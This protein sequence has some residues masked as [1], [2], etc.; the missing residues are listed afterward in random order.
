MPPQRR[1]AA[2]HQAHAQHNEALLDFLIADVLGSRSNFSDWGFV[3]AFYAALHYTKAAMM[4]KN[5]ANYVQRHQGHYENGI[6]VAGH[7]DLV[8]RVFPE[9]HDDYMDLFDLGLQARY[10][11]F[12]LMGGAMFPELKRKRETLER[13]K[14]GL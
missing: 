14:A 9:L 12:Y 8:E 3:I 5:P 7:N 11:G 2:E 13:I 1:T 10:G 4:Q 6:W